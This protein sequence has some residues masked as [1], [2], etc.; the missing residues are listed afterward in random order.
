MGK[1]HILMKRWTTEAPRGWTTCPKSSQRM[2]HNYHTLL[3]ILPF[4]WSANLPTPWTLGTWTQTSFF[5]CSQPWWKP[6]LS[7]F[8]SILEATD[9]PLLPLTCHWVFAPRNILFLTN[10]ILSDPLWFENH[11]CM[12]SLV[13]GGFRKMP[14]RTT[15][16]L[17]DKALWLK[18]L[19]CCYLGLKRAFMGTT[20]PHRMEP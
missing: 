4:H 20:Y 9:K 14:L 11:V 7:P 3:L 12:K 17:A 19:F 13:R 6:G 5:T 8:L 16:F 18:L 10:R 1:V 15:T 2:R